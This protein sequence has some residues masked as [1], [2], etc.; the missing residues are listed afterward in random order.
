MN[1]KRNAFRSERL[2]Q[3]IDS[4]TIAERFPRVAGIIIR[5][6][7]IQQGIAQNM[8]RTM[9]FSPSSYA[10][11]RVDCLNKSCVDGGFDLTQR[12]TSMIKQRKATA[13]GEIAC[14]G[15]GPAADHSSIVY[16]I[17]INYTQ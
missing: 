10:L 14:E 3:R 16:E 15:E 4:G 13:T 12:I 17:A 11:F 1:S 9:H 8:S 6:E 5:M 2:Q 7:Y